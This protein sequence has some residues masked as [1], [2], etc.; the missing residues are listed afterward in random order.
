MSYTS[1]IACIA[2]SAGRQLYELIVVK[3]RRGHQSL[4]QQTM[5]SEE[6]DNMTTVTAAVDQLQHENGGD[7]TNTNINGNTSANVDGSGNTDNETEEE[8]DID[9]LGDYASSKDDNSKNEYNEVD[10]DD[11]DEGIDFNDY[12]A[13]EEEKADVIPVPNT[14]N[15]EQSEHANEDVDEDVDAEAEVNEDIDASKETN[16]KQPT[17]AVTEDGANDESEHVD[18][19]DMK[20]IDSEQDSVIHQPSLTMETEK[21][22]VQR[23]IPELPP[24]EMPIAPSTPTGIW[25]PMDGSGNANA[26]EISFRETSEVLSSPPNLNM[27]YNRYQTNENE[28]ELKT[29]EDRVDVQNGRTSLKK[30][31]N[32]IKTG[33]G[34]TQNEQLINRIDWEFWSQVFN[35]YSNIVK[36]K[37]EELKMNITNGIPPEIRGMVWQILSDSNTVHLKNFFI[38]S[39]NMESTYSK[40]IRRDLARTSFIRNSQMNDKLDDLFNIIKAYSL[41]D[42]EV[43][44][45]QGMAFLTVPLLMNMEANEAFCM[46]VRLMFTYGFRD[47]Y[48]PEMPGLHLKIYQFDRLLEDQLPDLFAHLRHENVK[49]S[50]YAI[51]WFLTLFAYKFPLEMVLRIFD[52]V[53]TEG[54]DAILKFALNLMI[55]NKDHLITLQFD[56]LLKFLKENLFYYYSEVP[57][58]PQMNENGEQAL[59][60]DTDDV[61][62]KYQIDEF[63]RDSMK[64]DILPLTLNKYR[65]EFDEIDILEKQRQ[66]QILEL[67]AKNG[68]L[69]REIRKIEATY[70]IL[71]KEHVEI[72]NEMIKGKMRIGALEE[73]NRN[74]NEQIA[75]LQQRLENLTTS[76]TPSTTMSEGFDFS[77]QLSQGLDK[78]IQSA[79]E[80]N[81]KVMDE[82]QVLEDKLAQLEAENERLRG[83]KGTHPGVFGLRKGKFW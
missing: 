53:I 83:G 78:E 47:L 6:Q 62:G 38:E 52:V 16:L 64:V 73:E 46:L 1:N 82:N 17:D 39:K 66:A 74:L 29:S 4:L 7:D 35:D 28:L 23:A 44:Y 18:I 33:V 55:R 65:R 57:Q 36:N 49:S 58:I 31:F 50:M 41:Y 68:M 70:A 42:T 51:Q 5:A 11:A 19:D 15:V 25:F 8:D 26:N 22:Y 9:V 48:L 81:L 37:Q 24:R 79:M 75:E 77:G 2:I 12:A 14:E 69:T 32:E 40:M 61:K 20:S 10:E 45:T 71:N 72:A 67:Q 59:D 21:E 3:V 43:G 60:A 76:R 34:M 56:D 80:A 13:P 30:T 63:L 54:L 27:A